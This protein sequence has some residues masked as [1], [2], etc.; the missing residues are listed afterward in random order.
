MIWGHCRACCGGRDVGLGLSGSRPERKVG[1][2][3]ESSLW[4]PGSCSG[5]SLPL[6]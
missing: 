4:P 5:G 3:E 6:H 1:L 2:R